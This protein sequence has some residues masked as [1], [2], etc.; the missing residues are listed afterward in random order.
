[1]GKLGYLIIDDERLAREEMKWSLKSYPDLAFLGEASNAFQ[2]EELINRLK[3]D[4]IFLDVQMPGKTGFEL[5]EELD[6]VPAVIFT[7]AFD[8]YAVKA[9]EL[10][11]LDYLVKP[12][13]Q[14]R[15]EK[16]ILKIRQQLQNI[17]TT[18]PAHLFVK[19]GEKYHFIAFKD[20]YLIESIGNYA[21]LYF[22]RE[23][24]F[25][26]RSLNQLEKTLD[27]NLFFRINRNTMINTS[28]I[29][30]VI[31]DANGRLSFQLKTGESYRASSRQS[32]LF[33]NRNMF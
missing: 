16:A 9:F 29:E 30:Q 2:A 14:E 3:P 20:L 4:L 24:V 17:N 22:N 33:K 11:A 1:M 21:R 12:V 8:Q 19:E 10:N 23:K 25:F 28:F 31:P 15:L 6:H 5:L 13:R 18:K 32:A 27:P 26:K 7:T